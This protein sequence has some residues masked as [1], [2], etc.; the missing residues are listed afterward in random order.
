MWAET[1]AGISAASTSLSSGF[2]PNL[3]KALLRRSQE[4]FARCH[5]A[6]FRRKCR[7]GGCFFA[8]PFDYNTPIL[9]SNRIRSQEALQESMDPALKPPEQQSQRLRRRAGREH[10]RR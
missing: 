7:L 9:I 5:F 10:K 6:G 1:Q 8:L 4:S 3:S 2:L